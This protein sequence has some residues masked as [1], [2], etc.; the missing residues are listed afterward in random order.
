ME[1]QSRQD[2]SGPA[3][4]TNPIPC[5]AGILVK[6]YNNIYRTTG[7]IWHEASSEGLARIYAKCDREDRSRKRDL[8][9]MRSSE[10][11]HAPVFSTRN[12]RPS[13]CN[14]VEGHSSGLRHEVHERLIAMHSSSGGLMLAPRPTL[15]VVYRSRG[16]V[17]PLAWKTVI[18][19]TWTQSRGHAMQRR[20]QLY[21][22][23]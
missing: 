21:T 19:E 18:P 6:R 14:E 17:E 8:N 1:K 2:S 10:A 4:P 3:K 5:S 13:P 15:E 23:R 22:K 20:K 9:E 11:S 7:K 12:L 16:T